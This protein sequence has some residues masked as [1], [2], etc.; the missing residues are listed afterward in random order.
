MSAN[1]SLVEHPADSRTTWSLFG[2]RQ[3][4]NIQILKYWGKSN[5][6]TLPQLLKT[7][8]LTCLCAGLCHICVISYLAPCNECWCLP[9][10]GSVR[11]HCSYSWTCFRWFSILFVL[12]SFPFPARYKSLNFPCCLFNKCVLHLGQKGLSWHRGYAFVKKTSRS[13]KKK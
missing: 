2:S 12:D 8:Y 9:P 1:W 6:I 11:H 13:P 5:S 4:K 10:F 3:S 7:L